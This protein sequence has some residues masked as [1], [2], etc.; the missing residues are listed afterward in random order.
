MMH[1]HMPMTAD[2]CAWC[3]VLAMALA[4]LSMVILYA[5]FSRLGPRPSVRGR[6][7]C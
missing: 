1:V 4:T 5:V 7:R 3:F 2:E 6:G